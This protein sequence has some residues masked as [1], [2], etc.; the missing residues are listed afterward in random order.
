[1]MVRSRCLVA[2]ARLAIVFQST[3]EMR[4]TKLLFPL[5]TGAW[6]LF[7]AFACYRLLS[8]QAFAQRPR[9]IQLHVMTV[10]HNGPRS[11]NGGTVMDRDTPSTIDNLDASSRNI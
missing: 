10:M 11:E 8:I 9:D 4:A 5:R 6:G 3:L 7:V 2:T 1:M